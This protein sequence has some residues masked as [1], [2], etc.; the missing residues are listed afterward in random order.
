MALAARQMDSANDATGRIMRHIA[1]SP[2]AMLRPA[3][4]LLAGKCCGRLRQKHIQTAAL[5]ELIHTATLLHDDVIDSAALRRGRPAVRSVWGNCCAVL[6]GDSLLAAAFGLSGSIGSARMSRLL[7]DTA[8][9]MCDGEIRQNLLRNRWDITERTYCRIIEDKTARFFSTC[10]ALGA[11]ASEA[12]AREVRQLA[13][14][15]LHLGMAFQHTDDLLDIVGEQAVTRKT[16]GSD[17][18]NGELTLAFI[19]MLAALDVTRRRE[20]V[21]R[22]NAG[23][24]STGDFLRLL[25][26]TGSLRYVFDVVRRHIDEAMLCLERID[27]GPARAA[28]AEIAAS[29]PAR[30]DESR[31]D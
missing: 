19:R 23:K 8:R 13:D 27:S 9:T 16:N 20:V 6:A 28:L 2:G 3:L 29:V 15:G 10:C 11:I 17:L 18:A 4:V 21:G 24:R 30:V 26:K 14:F 1:S 5:V 22:L 25:R 31:L 12:G 7:A